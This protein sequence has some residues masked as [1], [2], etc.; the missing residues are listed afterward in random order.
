MVQTLER[1]TLFGAV[2]GILKLD[3]GESAIGEEVG[4]DTGSGGELEGWDGCAL[5]LL[6]L[7]EVSSD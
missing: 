7:A 2:R 6:F 1:L 3:D 5:I 4:G